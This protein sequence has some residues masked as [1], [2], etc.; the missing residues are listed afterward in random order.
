MFSYYFSWTLIANLPYP[1]ACP[2]LL[3]VGDHL[4]CLGGVCNAAPS[5]CILGP[6]SLYNF[7]VYDSE[8]DKWEE[9]GQLMM[10]RHNVPCCVRGK[11]KIL[12][13]FYFLIISLSDN[14]M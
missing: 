5:G 8:D 13:L 4:Y 3:S 7:D 14:S 6:N 12:P 11:Y 9:A 1:R 10:P 2:T